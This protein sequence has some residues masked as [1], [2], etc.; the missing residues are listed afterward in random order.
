MGL[1]REVIVDPNRIFYDSNVGQHHHLYHM[2]TGTLVD[3]GFEQVGRARMT[4]RVGRH[5][6]LEAGAASGIPAHLGDRTAG[7]GAAGL[8]ARKEKRLCRAMRQ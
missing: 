8:C 1:V 3:I 4:Q 2:D 7:D 6:F 5:P